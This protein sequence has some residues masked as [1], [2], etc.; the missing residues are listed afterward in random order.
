[1]KIYSKN[2]GSFH[3]SENKQRVRGMSFITAFLVVAAMV[4]GIAISMAKFQQS[5]LASTNSNISVLQAY[6]FAES[7]L[8]VLTQT[9]ILTMKKHR[10]PRLRK[11]FIVPAP[12]KALI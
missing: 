4:T 6:Q 11:F 2:T 8:D 9:Y 5:S 10:V 7:K 1:M 3:L 12:L